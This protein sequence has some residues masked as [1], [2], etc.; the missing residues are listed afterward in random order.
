[1]TGEGK[2]GERVHHR[3]P[4]KI[5]IAHL[6][7]EAA[8]VH[9]D[10]HA[11]YTSALLTRTA[12]AL[13]RRGFNVEIRQTRDEILSLIEEIVPADASVGVGGSVTVR[14]LGIPDI[15][16][17]RGN[18]VYDHWREG[19][20]KEEVYETRRRQLT[21]DF[22][23]TSTNALT[24]DGELVNIDGAGN[25]VA[26]M[27]FGPRHVIVIAGANKIARSVEEAL[28]RVRNIA[29][30]RNCRRLALKNPCATT[31]RCLDC[32]SESTACRITTIISRTP[33]ASEYTVILTPL[34]LG[35]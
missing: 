11:W 14:E 20:A 32:S 3:S 17:Q 6:F 8:K 15:L 7:W 1:M 5:G 30:P 35:F 34:M 24:I 29:S 25:R 23:L 2:P 27:S 16:T 31:G 21:A 26:A 19:L 9:E 33:M 10:I 12:D 22:F 4:W 18:T 13:G 28:W